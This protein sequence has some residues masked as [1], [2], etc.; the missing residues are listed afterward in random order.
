[1][2]NIRSLVLVVLGIFATGCDSCTSTTHSDAAVDTTVAQDVVV[3]AT[4]ETASDAPVVVDAAPV[5]VD[6]SHD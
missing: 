1:M 2:Q 5:G 3:E 6:A 4:V